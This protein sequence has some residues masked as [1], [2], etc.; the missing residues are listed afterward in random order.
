MVQNIS[1]QID[2]RICNHNKPVTRTTVLRDHTTTSRC[3]DKI[4]A[5]HKAE[6][7]SA[8][9]MRL[10]SYQHTARVNGRKASMQGTESQ[11]CLIV[12]KDEISM[13]A[14]RLPS[15]SSSAPSTVV[16]TTKRSSSLATDNGSHTVSHSKALSSEILRD[17][18]A[19]FSTHETLDTVN[20]KR[21]TYWLTVDLNPCGFVATDDKQ[22]HQQ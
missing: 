7:L 2:V 22:Q 6:A 20:N 21:W 8:R 4:P 17:T 16:E 14:S 3:P 13:L 11:G 12:P 15:S 9:E 18:R 1:L 19:E 5:G 10:K